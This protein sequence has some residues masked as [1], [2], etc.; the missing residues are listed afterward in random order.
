MVQGRF[1]VRARFVSCLTPRFALHVGQ[2][3][4]DFRVLDYGRKVNL[5][6][7]LVLI[8]RHGYHY[9]GPC[10]QVSNF[11]QTRHHEGC[12][13]STERMEYLMLRDPFWDESLATFLDASNRYTHAEEEMRKQ[14]GLVGYGEFLLM[15]AQVQELGVQAEEAHSAMVKPKT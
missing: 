5:F 10:R 6:E 12:F 2:S 8:A 11:E 7:L 3:K 9:R 4:S 13:N 14:V 15:A 1:A